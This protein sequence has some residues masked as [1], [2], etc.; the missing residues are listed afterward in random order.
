MKALQTEDWGM[1]CTGNICHVLKDKFYSETELFRYS[2]IKSVSYLVLKVKILAC[3]R[4]LINNLKSIWIKRYTDS[5]R[6]LMYQQ[7]TD[8]TKKSAH[9][10]VT[11]KPSV[12]NL[13]SWTRNIS[14]PANL[15]P[16]LSFYYHAYKCCTS[17]YL[18]YNYDSDLQ[19]FMFTYDVTILPMAPCTECFK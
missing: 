14:S 16:I 18:S 3:W 17:S 4:I 11:V 7:D 15:P 19:I 2:D 12:V 9:I 6:G 1:S 5:E 13:E 8:S 10:F